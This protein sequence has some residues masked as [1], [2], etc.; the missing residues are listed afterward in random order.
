MMVNF[1]ALILRFQ[2]ARCRSSIETA[3]RLVQQAVEADKARRYEEA[4]SL[5]QHALVYFLESLNCELF[6]LLMASDLSESQ[7]TKYFC[8]SSDV[9][10]QKWY[11]TGLRNSLVNHARRLAY[12]SSRI[13]SWSP[14]NGRYQNLLVG[15]HPLSVEH[16]EARLNCS[17]L[18]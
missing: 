3:L 11:Y 9:V 14:Q 4:L 10:N 17:L 13:I 8:T 15:Y 18:V 16:L 12:F 5:Y 6:F 1:T 2:E 7:T